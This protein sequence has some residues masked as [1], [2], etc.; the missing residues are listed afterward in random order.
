MAT[1]KKYRAVSAFNNK[2]GELVMPGAVVGESE[3]PSEAKAKFL[4]LGAI[5][6]IIGSVSRN[7]CADTSAFE[8]ANYI[9]AL[10]AYTKESSSKV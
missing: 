1:A 5:E 4:K 8:R 10:V 6:Q 3:I 2:D 9:K 7:K